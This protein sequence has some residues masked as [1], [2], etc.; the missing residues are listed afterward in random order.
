MLRRPPRST[1][2]PYTTL[3]RSLRILRL[4]S[5]A[6]FAQDDTAASRPSTRAWLCDPDGVNRPSSRLEAAVADRRGCGM[7]EDRR[8][9]RTVKPGRG[10]Y[11]IGRGVL[12]PPGSF[13]CEG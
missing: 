6:R 11:V 10:P 5:Q 9:I 2:F 1:L 7:T 3:F 13:W 8:S 4:R 12:T